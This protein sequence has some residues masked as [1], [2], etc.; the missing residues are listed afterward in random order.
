[1]SETPRLIEVYD[2]LTS[3]HAHRGWHWVETTDPFEIIVGSILVQN[4]AWTNVEKALDSLGSAHVLT[5]AAMRALSGEALEELVRPSGQ[6][7]QKAKKLAAFLELE[8]RYG[9][10]AELL[11]MSTQELRTALL[12]TWGI[13]PE[14]ADVIVLYAAKQPSFVIDAYTLRLFGRLGIGPDPE[15]TYDTWREFFQD[16]LQTDVGLWGRYHSL[17]VMHCKYLC[18]KRR[19]RCGQCELAPRCPAAEADDP[20]G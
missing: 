10:L 6:Y 18:Q 2:R 9:G 20:D 16:S 15:A 4:T 19:P 3:M 11:S 1:M 5:V 14:T 8:E 7:R 17:I 13:G 12:A